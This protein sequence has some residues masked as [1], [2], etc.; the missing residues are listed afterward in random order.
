MEFLLNGVFTKKHINSA[1]AYAIDFI[2]YFIQKLRLY[3]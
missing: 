3:R 1:K 2:F